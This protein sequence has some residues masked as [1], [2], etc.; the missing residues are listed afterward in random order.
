MQWTVQWFNQ[1]RIKGQEEHGKDK[2]PSTAHETTKAPGRTIAQRIVHTSKQASIALDLGPTRESVTEG[3]YF[4]KS[5]DPMSFH[6]DCLEKTSNNEAQSIRPLRPR[7]SAERMRLSPSPSPSR[8]AETEGP[9]DYSSY[10]DSVFSNS[11]FSTP[12]TP[13]SIL[14][15]NIGASVPTSAP[16][17]DSTEFGGYGSQMLPFGPWVDL[18]RPRRRKGKGRSINLQKPKKFWSQRKWDGPFDWIK[19]WEWQTG[20]GEG[21]CHHPERTCEQASCICTRNH[22]ACKE[23]CSCR[24]ECKRR[25]R[26]CECGPSVRCDEG[27]CGCATW[28]RECGTDC[29]CDTSCGNR[30]DDKTLASRCLLEIRE[31]RIPDAGNGV[32]AR[33]LI[34][35]GTV[36]GEFTGVRVKDIEINDDDYRDKIELM[37]VSKDYV[38]ICDNDCDMY[39]INTARHGFLN[40]EVYMCE[41]KDRRKVLVRTKAGITIKP[42]DEIYIDYN[43]DKGGD[44]H[45]IRDPRA[46]S[47]SVDEQNDNEET[48][49]SRQN[50]REISQKRID[51]V[52]P[53]SESESQSDPDQ[54]FARRKS[55]RKK[56][57]SRLSQEESKHSADY[58]RRVERF[59]EMSRND[60]LMREM[61]MRRRKRARDKKDEEESEEWQAKKSKVPSS[62]TETIVVN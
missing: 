48:A 25:F 8:I 39:V 28:S 46:R 31:S 20:N 14:S 52:Q 54:S 36:L 10:R 60:E 4:Q 59:R 61:D 33:K 53:K 17:P 44:Q 37:R 26:P 2:L 3:R 38:M 9:N 1:H 27:L 42:G 32:F 12:F 56:R 58:L 45:E 19:H 55:Q 40:A 22:T 15:S 23:S 18:P 49:A 43:I 11:P 50:E 13:P 5:S 7:H 21:G 29:G 47:Q 34:L 41:N 6:S 35:P 24:N 57:L 30:F 62:H 51:D 16:I